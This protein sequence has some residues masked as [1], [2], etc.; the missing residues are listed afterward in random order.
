MSQF[1]HSFKSLKVLGMKLSTFESNDR[2][3]FIATNL[4]NKL[5]TNA[6]QPVFYGN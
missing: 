2:F 4:I 1:S 3:K 5:T 6:L